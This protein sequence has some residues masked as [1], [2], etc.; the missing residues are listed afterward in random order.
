MAAGGFT[1]TTFGG[2]AGST[3]AAM[4]APLMSALAGLPP[5]PLRGGSGGMGGMKG[6]AS[7]ITDWMEMGES[8]GVVVASIVAPEEGAPP[9]KELLLESKPADALRSAAP[10]EKN[11]L[12]MPTLKKAR[13][14]L[15]QKATFKTNIE[16]RVMDLLLT[17]RADGSFPES[18]ILQTWLG[19]RW[20]ALQERAQQASS[21]FVVYTLAALSLL[22]K[23]A[24]AQSSLWGRAEQKAQR[25]LDQQSSLPKLDDIL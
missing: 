19:A 3:M 2:L 10:K 18:T 9:E 4:G 22:R 5:S 15:P 25:W 16:D 6:A 7:S 21:S 24:A 13:K 20:A 11:K 23:E 12:Q 1:N 17:Q 8:D 14:E